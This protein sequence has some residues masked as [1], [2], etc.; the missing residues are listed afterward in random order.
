MLMCLP[1]IEVM[2]EIKKNM[3]SILMDGA[4]CVR[5]IRYYRSDESNETSSGVIVVDDM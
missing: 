4:W 2:Q 3:V 1:L 5:N